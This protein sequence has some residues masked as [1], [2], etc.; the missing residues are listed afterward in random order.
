MRL[1]SDKVLLTHQPSNSARRTT[2]EIDIMNKILI[3]VERYT[4]GTDLRQTGGN[5]STGCTAVYIENGK[6]KANKIYMTN[7]GSSLLFYIKSDGKN[8]L[9]QSEDVIYN[10]HTLHLTKKLWFIEK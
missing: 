5:L 7:T 9:L 1:N 10:L 2:K 6:K 3:A 8:V 4:G